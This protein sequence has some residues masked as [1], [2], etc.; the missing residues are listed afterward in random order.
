MWNL[1][2][3]GWRRSLQRLVAQQLLG[4][5]NALLKQMVVMHVPDGSGNFG[6]GVVLSEYGQVVGLTLE[7]PVLMVVPI[8]GG[9]RCSQS[10]WVGV[11]VVVSVVF[12]RDLGWLLFSVVLCGDEVLLVLA[13]GEMNLW[14][15]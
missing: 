15:E 2:C 9:E 4:E 1:V 12:V 3:L 6:Y 7:H 13:A 11:D 8:Q 5:A 10:P 14:W